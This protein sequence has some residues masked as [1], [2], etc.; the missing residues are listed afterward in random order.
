MD[1]KKQ[2]GRQEGKSRTFL[3]DGDIMLVNAKTQDRRRLP[4]RFGDALASNALTLI[5]AL[6]M[7]W[8]HTYENVMKRIGAKMKQKYGLN[9]DLN[10]GPL[11][12]WRDPKQEF[13]H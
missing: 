6:T 3:I 9:W 2:R 5:M 11:T 4:S 10:P 13:C 7:F 8:K 12:N 1:Q